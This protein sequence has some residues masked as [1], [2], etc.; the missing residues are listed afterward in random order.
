MNVAFREDLTG[1][2]SELGARAFEAR[3]VGAA[4][5][6]V[7]ELAP[8]LTSIATD[9]RVDEPRRA[10]A[11]WLNDGAVYHDAVRICA[12]YVLA[13]DVFA[14][15]L[16]TVYVP[17]ARDDLEPLLDL[18][19]DVL[20]WLTHALSERS[21]IVLRP[22]PLHPLGVMAAPAWADGRLCGPGDFFFHDV[23]HAR[24]KV[25]EDLLAQGIAI[26]DAYVDGD[27]VDPTTQRHR[28]ILPTARAH[29]DGSG[30]K[31]A[32]AGSDF[33]RAILDGIDAMTDRVL[34]DAA[35]V[36]F[37]EIL[38]EK[39]IAPYP[40]VLCATLRDDAH[41]RKILKKYGDGFYGD[42][43]PASE[44]IARLDDAGQWLR[45]YCES[46]LVVTKAAC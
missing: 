19:P 10:A 23:D 14:P 7:P 6:A 31:R 13:L 45:T 35:D 33:V 30:W 40:R 37:F 26:P 36:L 38:H 3:Q 41:C 16:S 20:A 8:I 15:T 5:F 43:P 11:C 25:R 29:V 24:F 2:A 44:C 17:K 32:I 27:T 4:S 9:P 21:L 22:F 1:F 28:S 46:R 39:S 42:V 12:R 34:K 18:W